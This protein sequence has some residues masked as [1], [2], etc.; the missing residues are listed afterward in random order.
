[1]DLSL[2]F[3]VETKAVVVVVNLVQLTEGVLFEVQF[4]VK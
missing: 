3:I 1:M 2:V 4:L